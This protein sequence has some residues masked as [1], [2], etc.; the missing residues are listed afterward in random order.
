MN[1]RKDWVG[2]VFGVI[3]FLASILVLILSL[4]GS[5]KGQIP[6]PRFLLIIYDTLGIIPGAVV[7]MIL[8]A[9]L[10]FFS[11]KGKEN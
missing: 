1:R 7:Q 8:S 4:T 3:W 2:I 5:L 6:V 11:V 10:I 9:L